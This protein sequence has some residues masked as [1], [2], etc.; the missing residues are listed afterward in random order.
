MGIDALLLLPPRCSCRATA[1]LQLLL[2]PATKLLLL[3]AAR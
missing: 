3:P 2:P 1:L